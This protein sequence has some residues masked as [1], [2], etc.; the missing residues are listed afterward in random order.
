MGKPAHQVGTIILAAR[1]WIR[2]KNSM[3]KLPILLFATDHSSDN[4]MFGS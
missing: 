4:D 1:T 3:A 2:L